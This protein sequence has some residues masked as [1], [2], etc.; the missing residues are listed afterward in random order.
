MSGATRLVPASCNIVCSATPSDS[1][2]LQQRRL[3]H[4]ACL[5]TNGTVSR[6]DGTTC[7]ILPDTYLLIRLAIVPHLPL[8]SFFSER[9]ETHDMIFGSG[10]RYAERHGT[11]FYRLCLRPALHRCWR[12]AVILFDGALWSLY[13]LPRLRAGFRNVVTPVP[14][15]HLQTPHLTWRRITR[16]LPLP[17]LLFLPPSLCLLSF[18][19]VLRKATSSLDVAMVTPL[20]RNPAYILFSFHDFV[21]TTFSA[22]HRGSYFLHEHTTHVP[23]SF[24]G[25]CTVHFHWL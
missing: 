12:G 20:P 22:K 16:L 25:H 5:H 7:S 15:L 14:Y 9:F 11:F 18:P 8:P 21:S 24:G 3:L 23:S 6:T 13:C 1:C 10:A 2:R 4:F 19:H 17:R